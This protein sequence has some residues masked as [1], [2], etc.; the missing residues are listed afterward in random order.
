[1]PLWNTN[2]YTDRR[3]QTAQSFGKLGDT[4]PWDIE[5]GVAPAQRDRTERFRIDE[6][7][8]VRRLIDDDQTGSLIAMTFNEFGHAILSQENGP[9]LLA[10]DS[11]GDFHLDK[12]RT[13]CDQVKSC[14]GIL[15]LNGEVFVTGMGPEGYALYR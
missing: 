8:E 6:N 5:E 15:A 7:F 14:Q 3:W 13:Y 2:I 12:V 9:L 1:M 4:A 10:Y 11:N